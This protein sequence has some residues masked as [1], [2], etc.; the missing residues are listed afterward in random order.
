MEQLAWHT[1]HGNLAVSIT[2]VIRRV[3]LREENQISAS[4]LYRF[5]KSDDNDHSSTQLPVPKTLALRAGVRG[6]WPFIG[7]R[8][9]GLMQKKVV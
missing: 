9:A 4:P 5:F 8:I 1:G 3:F 6:P 2:R 7:W